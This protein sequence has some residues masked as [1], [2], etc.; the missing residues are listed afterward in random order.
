MLGV[1][2]GEVKLDP[3]S[4]DWKRLY[5]KEQQLLHTIIGN[6]IVELQHIGS[7]SIQQI[8]AKPIIDILI[9]VDDLSRIEHFDE[10]KLNNHGYYQLSKVHVEGKRVFAKFS[11]LEK[12]TKTHIL[13]VVR[14]QGLLWN[15][16]T[17]FRDYMND[18]REKAKEYETLKQELARKHPH[19]E[20]SYTIEK[21]KF[22]DGIIRDIN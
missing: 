5:K 8:S 1:N 2:K 14:Y 3:P 18:N 4:E 7:T 10:T 15:Q 21:K 6:D 11:N 20:R 17:Y 13:H 19:D 16:L 12:L 22:V 9:G